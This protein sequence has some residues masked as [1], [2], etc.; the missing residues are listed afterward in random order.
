MRLPQIK[1]PGRAKTPAEPEPA[2]ESDPKPAGKGRPTP[3]RQ[4]SA[5]PPPPPTTRK[6]AYARMRDRPKDQRVEARKGML[7]GDERYVL[8]RDRGP[9][10]RLVRDIVDARRNVG[11]YFFGVAIAILLASSLPNLDTKIKVAVSYL[12]LVMIFV[13]AGDSYLLARVIRR[14][15]VERFPDDTD[16][17]RRHVFYGVTRA[18]TFRRMRS[19]RPAVKIGTPV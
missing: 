10:R 8:P 18:A 19:P 11:S 2:P 15:I 7:E 3:K 6:E 13:L 16:P 14:A 5:P 1:L 12:W 17:I 9:V 4:R